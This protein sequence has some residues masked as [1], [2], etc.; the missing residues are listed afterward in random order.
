[1]DYR[2]IEFSLQIPP[3]LKVKNDKLKYL[4]K[5][6]L[7]NYLPPEILMRTKHGFGAP[8]ETWMSNQL[9]DYVLELL[10]PGCKIEG[11]IKPDAIRNIKD[12]FYMNNGK[13]NYRDVFKLWLLVAIEFWMRQYA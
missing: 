1:L 12:R 13:R 2:L 6:A 7:S 4:L 10:N 3:Q 8:V 9:K 11:F 5:K